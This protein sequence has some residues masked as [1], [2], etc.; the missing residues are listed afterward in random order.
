MW[1]FLWSIDFLILESFLV[2]LSLSCRFLCLFIDDEDGLGYNGWKFFGILGKLLRYG[3]VVKFVKV[4]LDRF[5]FCI[6]IN[7]GLFLFLFF[8]IVVGCRVRYRELEFWI[9]KFISCVL[10]S[11]WRLWLKIE[12]FVNLRYN[13]DM[14]ML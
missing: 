4:K 10:N 14:K 13:V 11:K 3:L 12:L 2:V 5:G 9:W 6:I 7:V 8:E 1:L